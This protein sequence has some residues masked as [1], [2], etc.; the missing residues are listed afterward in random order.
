MAERML[1][2]GRGSSRGTAVLIFGLMALC[3][4]L[5]CVPG[6]GI[7]VFVMMR[8]GLNGQAMPIDQAGGAAVIMNVPPAKFEK[9]DI[10]KIEPGMTV[11]EVNALIGEGRPA[12]QN[13]MRQAFGNFALGADAKWTNAGREAGV[14]SWRQ[15][16][17]GDQR[18]FVGFAK[19]QKSGR[20][21][22]VA[23]FWVRPLPNGFE[24]DPGIMPLP[25]FFG[26]D[27]DDIAKEREEKNKHLNDPKFKAG[28]P[29]KKILAKW[30]TDRDNGFEFRAD[31]TYDRIGRRYQGKY[32]FVAADEIELHIPPGGEFVGGPALTE[33]HKIWVSDE[34]LIMQLLPH[35]LKL[36]YKRA[37]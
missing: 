13:D 28:D 33:R 10:H 9:D 32:K 3:T 18:I 34:E 2:S 12:N 4:C 25:A 1:E 36:T 5:I 23:S 26:G 16:K 7:G 35:R 21:R 31:G 20:D 14:S 19:G 17:N 30:L 29:K 24:S 8:H 6:V 22:A 37:N 11:D 27:P 15:W